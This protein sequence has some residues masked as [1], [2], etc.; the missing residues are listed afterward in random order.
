VIRVGSASDWKCKTQPGGNVANVTTNVGHYM[1]TTLFIGQCPHG[2][3]KYMNWKHFVTNAIGKPMLSC[4]E[5]TTL[6]LA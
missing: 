1:S 4:A 5:K 2:N 6:T 3:M